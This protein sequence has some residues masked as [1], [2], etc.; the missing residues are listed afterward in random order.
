MIVHEFLYIQA[1]K[2]S[3]G[4]VNESVKALTFYFKEWKQKYYDQLLWELWDLSCL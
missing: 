2:L 4:S 3:T 1:K